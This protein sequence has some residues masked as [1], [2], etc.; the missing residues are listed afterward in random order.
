MV[1]VVGKRT[2][3]E[4]LGKPSFLIFFDRETLLNPV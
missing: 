3:K 4:K 1:G 2:S